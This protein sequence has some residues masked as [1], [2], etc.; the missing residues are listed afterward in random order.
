MPC[1][2][3]C[4]MMSCTYYVVHASRQGGHPYDFMT[5]HNLIICLMFAQAKGLLLKL[6]ASHFNALNNNNTNENILKRILIVMQDEN[7]ADCNQNFR[8]CSEESIDCL[9]KW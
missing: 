8:I 3:A 9:Y 1:V 4:A 6:T 5:R 2:V 7:K